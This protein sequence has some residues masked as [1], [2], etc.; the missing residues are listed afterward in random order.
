MSEHISINAAERSPLESRKGI[1]LGIASFVLSVIAGFWVIILWAISIG[2]AEP[3]SGR[4]I[5]IVFF[6]FCAIIAFVFL[7]LTAITAT[8]SFRRNL[9]LGRV[10]AVLGSV[11]GGGVLIAGV[12][13]AV[14]VATA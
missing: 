8:F 1:A 14:A 3:G 9:R 4:P 2:A 12:A 5:A 11:V 7:I 10:W 13:L 6:T